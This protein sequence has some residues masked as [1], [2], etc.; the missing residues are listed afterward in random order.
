MKP[1]NLCLRI[2]AVLLAFPSMLLS[3]VYSLMILVMFSN[4]HFSRNWHILVFVVTVLAPVLSLA[5]C[6]NYQIR[7][8][9]T[10]FGLSILGSALGGVVL[11][12]WT[13]PQSRGLIH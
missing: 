1:G 8:T 12:L 2:L 4:F 11:M 13:S 5:G 3:F 7:L 10:S 6:V 9:W